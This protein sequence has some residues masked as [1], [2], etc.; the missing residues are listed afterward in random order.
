VPE[1]IKD[2]AKLI[3]GRTLS[4][5]GLDVDQ[6]RL[7]TSNAVPWIIDT[8]KWIAT[9]DVFLFEE[10]DAA[11]R[12]RLL[13]LDKAVLQSVRVAVCAA[14]RDVFIQIEEE[15]YENIESRNTITLTSEDSTTRCKSNS[16]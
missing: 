10:E 5:T 7:L 15:G 9:I 14:G 2:L 13:A 16:N 8:S 3:G 4:D 1:T 6:H 12:E 11:K